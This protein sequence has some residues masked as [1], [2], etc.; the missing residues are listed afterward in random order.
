M[1]GKK[2][3]AGIWEGYKLFAKTCGVLR[4]GFELV[5]IA[6]PSDGR[7]LEVAEAMAI[8]G[9]SVLEHQAKVAWL[10]LAM[11]SLDTNGRF[12]FLHKTYAQAAWL[13][14]VVALC[15]DVG[16]TA[17]GD[18][19]DD[20]RE[21][22]GGK[23][24]VERHVFGE[25]SHCFSAFDA[26]QTQGAFVSF[27]TLGSQNGRA[28]YALDKLEAVLTLLLCE[29]GDNVGRITNKPSLTE[30][31]RYYM[32]VAK[33]EEA[34]DCWGAHLCADI[35]DFPNIIKEPVLAILGAAFQDVRGKLPLWL[36]N[37]AC[38]EPYK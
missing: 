16:E 14:F 35:R 3:A 11:D 19:P 30:A 29:Q 21:A 25:M 23:A 12:F 38:I 33:A 13:D 36:T 28:V 4:S 24:V 8:R 6:P 34:A 37:A 5:G 2:E 15:H 26:K 1:I 22:H 9:E 18:I 31:D 17:I 27:Q 20:G 32:E 10:A 7:V